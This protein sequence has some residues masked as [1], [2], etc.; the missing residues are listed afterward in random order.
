MIDAK[1][2]IPMFVEARK[3]RK[4]LT[5]TIDEV[6]ATASFMVYCGQLIER[7]GKLVTENNKLR[8][9]DAKFVAGRLAAYVEDAEISIAE[10]QKYIASLAND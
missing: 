6:A 10:L 2:L 7:Y 4:P 5:L 9:T 1:H 8:K 3:E